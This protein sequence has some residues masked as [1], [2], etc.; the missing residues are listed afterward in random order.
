MI[1]VSLPVKR[2]GN[3]SET[4][5]VN[6]I[7]YIILQTTVILFFSSC[8]IIANPIRNFWANPSTPGRFDNID[9]IIPEFYIFEYIFWVWIQLYQTWRDS[10]KSK[11]WCRYF[12]IFRTF[13]DDKR[14]ASS[15]EKGQLFVK[16]T[17]A[18]RIFYLS[19]NDSS[20]KIQL[21]PNHWAWT[22]MKLL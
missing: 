9:D 18:Q 12:R 15:L 6:S 10:T 8:Q 3:N 2:K 4:N 5:S 16:F 21:Y 7:Y 1:N 13:L 14:V 22:K 19:G 20:R 11:L 17:L